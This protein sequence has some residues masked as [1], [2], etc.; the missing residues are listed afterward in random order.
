MS[1]S[2]SLLTEVGEIFKPEYIAPVVCYMCHE[3]CTENGVVI[4]VTI[5]VTKI[6]RTSF[7]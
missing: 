1:L 3:N 7:Y 5:D 6:F 4:E 2:F